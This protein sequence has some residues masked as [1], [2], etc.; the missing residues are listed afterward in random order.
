MLLH[1][2]VQKKAQEEI[3][4]VIRRDRL[5]ELSDHGSLT[6]LQ[7]V[8]DETMRWQPVLPI[9]I[10]HQ[11]T[12]DDTYRGMHIPKGAI[13]VANSRGL[14]WD[15]TKFHDPRSFKPERFLPKPDGAGEVPSPN[16]VYGWGRR[17]CAGRFLADNSVW[18][19][20]ARILAVFSITPLK[21][22]EG[23]L[24]KPD[25]K[26]TTEMTRHVKPF[27]CDILPRDEKARLL[28]IN[29]SLD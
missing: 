29:A 21:D 2:E 13:I 3:D 18:I 1:P 15:E 4:R 11:T 27:K 25:V 12:A 23:H 10:P 9:G 17:I 24:M 26:F 20:M 8:M 14:T 19:A 22:A 5:P 6:Y 7:C 16:T 28:I